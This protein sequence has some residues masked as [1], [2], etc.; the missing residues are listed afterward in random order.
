MEE[1]N[2]YYTITQINEFIH[3][4]FLN[5]PVF[6]NITLRGEISNFKGINRSGHLY[7]SLKD[8]KSVIS[9]VIF[10]YDAM[11]LKTNIKNGDDVI[12]TGTV[13]TYAN[14]GT[15]QIVIHD[16]YLYGQGSLL[17][18]RE[19]LKE[20]LDK[21][22]YFN[23]EHKLPLPQYPRKIAIITGKNSAAAVDFE[24]NIKRRWPIAE[25]NFFTCLVQGEKAPEDII[26]SL[27]DAVAIKP[28]LILL[29]RGGGSSDDLLAF[30]D[31]NV[32]KT[33]YNLDIP[34]IAAIG[35]EINRTFTDFVCDGYASTPT[36]AAEL[37]VP[38]YLDV[39]K[40]LNQDLQYIRTNVEGK[41]KSIELKLHKL[42]GL[43]NMQNIG[44]ILDKKKDYIDKIFDDIKNK[45]QQK[46]DNLSN[47][48]QRKMD[49]I[50]NLNPNSLLKKGYAIIK[51]LDDKVITSIADVKISDSI[52]INLN[53]G[54]I[55]AKVEE[56]K[57]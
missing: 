54:S 29:G 28:D 3:E 15:Y 27:N 49:L 35:H 23:P 4:L 40:G 53:D 2:K 11:R 48:V 26:K 18:K 14:G 30:D 1:K 25:L 22:G 38:N 12:V 31:E 46:L 41:I 55:E 17:L 5:V 16:L 37:A 33:I 9:A 47:T 51:G 10:K 56:I 34:V 7:F 36:G 32:V 21:E 24:I 43:K 42:D 50:Q 44:F 45:Y 52:S 13:Q 39:L 20:K 57:K 8:E 6:Q 19:A